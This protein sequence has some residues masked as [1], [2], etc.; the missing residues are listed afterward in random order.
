MLVPGRKLLLQTNHGN[1]FLKESKNHTE[2]QMLD[3]NSLLPNIPHTK[4]SFDSNDWFK[5]AKRMK[6][7]WVCLL[8]PSHNVLVVPTA[9]TPS[10]KH[11]STTCNQK[12][13]CSMWINIMDAK[14]K[15]E[16]KFKTHFN[17]ETIGF[18]VPQLHIRLVP[19]NKHLNINQ[20][21][22]YELI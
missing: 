16:S 5:K 7:P 13:W 14:M 11:F 2:V 22:L 18:H 6:K 10:I 3:T 9:P 15:L 1:I 4:T 20:C 19:T 21:W 12:E 17:I 8:T